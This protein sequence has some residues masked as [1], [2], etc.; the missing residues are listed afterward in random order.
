MERCKLLPMRHQRLSPP[1]DRNSLLHSSLPEPVHASRKARWFFNP[2]TGW[3]RR[4]ERSANH[5]ISRQIYPRITGLHRIYDT[6][7]RRRLT[8]AESEIGIRG[9]GSGFHGLRILLISDV[10]CGPF[11]SLDVLADTFRRSM[12]LKPDLILLAGDMAT[13]RGEELSRCLPA[14]RELQAG[15]GIYA[16]LGNHDHYTGVPEQVCRNM[17]DAGIIMLQNRHTILQMGGDRLVLAGIDDLAF[18]RPDLN[19]ALA[20]KPEHL[21][22]VL[23]SHN[24]D[25]FFDAARSRVDLVL[26]GHTHGGQIRCPGLPVLVRMSRFRLD[27]GRYEAAGSELVVSRGLG[28]VGLPLRFACP[29]EVVLL[30]LQP[31]DG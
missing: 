31:A 8:V 28:A 11:I 3:F 23:V 7:L 26:S 5:F 25:V 10:H 1:D 15:L 19:Q 29:P 27:E 30:I 12:A 22:V 16:V 13:G 17:E 2:V 18:G 14:F 6:I 24:P 9:L 4:L 20:G 21:P